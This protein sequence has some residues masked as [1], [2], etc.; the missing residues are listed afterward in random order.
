MPRCSMLCTLVSW[1]ID[2]TRLTIAVISLVKPPAVNRPCAASKPAA[3][4]ITAMPIAPSTCTNIDNVPR[5]TSIFSASA[6]LS[7]VCTP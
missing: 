5:V 4:S 7:L 2:G 3:T 1:R 6:T